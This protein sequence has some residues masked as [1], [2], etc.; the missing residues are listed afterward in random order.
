MTLFRDLDENMKQS[1]QDGA[2]Y[3]GTKNVPIFYEEL[4]EA[5]M[6]E[7]FTEGDEIL[8]IGSG[9][10]IMVWKELLSGASVTTLDL[11]YKSLTS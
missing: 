2:K 8:D 11:V 3:Y 4:R 7:H 1:L 5:I 10:G 9:I 6:S